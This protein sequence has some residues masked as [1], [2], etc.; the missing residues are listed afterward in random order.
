MVV[1]KTS[2]ANKFCFCENCSKK[3]AMRYMGEN[4]FCSRKCF[5]E[6]SKIGRRGQLTRVYAKRGQVARKKVLNNSLV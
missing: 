2:Y 4:K 6:Y 3:F 5:F 1:R